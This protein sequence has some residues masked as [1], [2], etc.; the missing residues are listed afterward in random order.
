MSENINPSQP[1]VADDEIDLRELFAAIWQGKWII[2]AVTAVFAVASVFYALSLPNIYKS[3]ALLAPASEQKSAGLSGQ[4]GG[5]AALAGVNLGSGAGVDKTAL[6]IEIIKSRDFL[7]RF[8]E[9]RIQLQDLMAVKSWDLASN[10]LNY[11]AEVYDLNNQQWLR[12]AKPPRQAKP[13]IQEAYKVLSDKLNI[14]TDATTGM[15]KLS[16]EHISPFIAQR[17]VQMLVADL[18]LEMKTRDIEEAEKSIA[19]LQQQISQTNISDLRA[20]LYSL[21]EEQTKTLMLANVRE[22]Y[23]LKVIDKPI[24]PEEKAK[25]ARP[26]IVIVFTFL[27]GFMAIIL[28]ILR[29]YLLQSKKSNQKS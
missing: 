27:G 13:S 8:I 14:S 7:G 3:E 21:V 18:N 25:P 5:L 11:D 26:I 29:Y 15:V 12:E 19:Y 24:V 16:V 9:K 10:T 23:A 17:W 2:I 4:L 22:E 28:V 20:A 6:A 1:T